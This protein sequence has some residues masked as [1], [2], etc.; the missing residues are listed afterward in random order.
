MKGQ[1]S[2]KIGLLEIENTKRV[3][4]ADLEFLDVLN[5]V[6][7]VEGI[8]LPLSRNYKKEFDLRSNTHL[9][10]VHIKDD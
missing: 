8:C 6:K 1:F 10:L 9:R 4:K 3:Q 5:V 2:S 7:D